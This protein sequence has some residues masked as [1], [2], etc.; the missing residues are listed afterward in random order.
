[1][2]KRSNVNV[3]GVDEVGRGPLAGPVVAAAVILED[4]HKISGLNDSK[5]LSEPQREELEAK[6]KSKQLPGQSDARRS[7]KLT[8]LISFKQVYWPCVGRYK[9]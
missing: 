8:R 4:R 5:A 2:I 1:M 3:A 6:I 9:P 7:R